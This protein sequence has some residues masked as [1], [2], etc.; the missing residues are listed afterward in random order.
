MS[1]CDIL[2]GCEEIDSLAD[3][4]Q[5]AL[6]IPDTKKLDAFHLAYAVHYR[7]PYLLTWNCAHLA[8]PEVELR[9]AKFCLRRDLW[10]P[11]VCTPENMLMRRE[12]G[13]DVERP[14]S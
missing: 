13:D 3:Q 9:L 7:V 2:D 6:G 10:V 1:G 14:H 5:A 12:D 8:D 4:I 11:V